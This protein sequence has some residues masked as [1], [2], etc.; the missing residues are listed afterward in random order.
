VKQKGRERKCLY[1]Q[2]QFT[3]KGMPGA[4]FKIQWGCKSASVPKVLTFFMT[5]QQRSYFGQNE[6]GYHSKMSI[7][8]DRVNLKECNGVGIEG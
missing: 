1:A 6:D 5:I 3:G 8:N 7:P 4:E 2:R